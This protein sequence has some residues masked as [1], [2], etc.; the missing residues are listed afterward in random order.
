MILVRCNVRC[1]RS[2]FGIVSYEKGIFCELWLGIRI[3]V[4]SCDVM[5]WVSGWCLREFDV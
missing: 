2:C 5:V 1:E 4:E 3:I